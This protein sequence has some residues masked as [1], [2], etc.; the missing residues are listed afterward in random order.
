MEGR[1]QFTLLIEIF[2]ESSEDK[3]SRLM[4]ESLTEE[5][6]REIMSRLLEMSR[7][8]NTDYDEQ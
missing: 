4:A 8:N 1:C 3:I 2:E 7:N 5:I 6:D